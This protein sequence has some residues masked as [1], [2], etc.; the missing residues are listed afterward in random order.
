MLRSEK[1]PRDVFKIKLSRINLEI[2]YTIFKSK[3]NSPTLVFCGALAI[4]SDL[5][6]PLA[7][8]AK[9][10]VKIITWRYRGVIEEDEQYL[11][12][13]SPSD[14]AK[15]LLDLLKSL[16]ETNVVI[17]GFCYGAEVALRAA[18]LDKQ[19]IISVIC[20]NGS[21]SLRSLSLTEKNQEYLSAIKPALDDYDKAKELFQIFQAVDEKRSEM[22][23]DDKKDQELTERE[24][25]KIINGEISQFKKTACQFYN[26]IK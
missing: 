12:A 4:S 10:D 14:H 13:L 2:E 3:K 21:F 16:N 9:G 6:N 7:T 22:E 20:V 18:S 26:L 8:Q 19:R 1:I 23:S 24:I 25:N 5:L 17:V 11:A 15:D